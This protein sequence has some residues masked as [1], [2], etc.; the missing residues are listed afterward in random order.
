MRVTP[1]YKGAQI[2]TCSILLPGENEE[3]L[4]SFIYASNS[5]EERKDLWDDLR[6]HYEAPMFKNKRW[7]LMGDYNEILE[8]E[9]HSGFG[10]SPRIPL[11]MRDFQDMA[12]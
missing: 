3:F 12:N 1:V 8:G 10:D 7:M 11:G 4:C 9:E 5:M 2:I 6:L